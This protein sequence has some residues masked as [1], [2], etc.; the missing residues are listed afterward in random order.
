MWWEIIPSFAIITTVMAVPAYAN[1]YLNLGVLG[2]VR[3]IQLF[4]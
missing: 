2:N 4:T 1:Y 3:H